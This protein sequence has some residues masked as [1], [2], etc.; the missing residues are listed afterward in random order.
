MIKHI[1]DMDEE[2]KALE[3]FN[4]EKLWTRFFKIYILWNSFQV[5]RFFLESFLKI[6][7]PWSLKNY[8]FS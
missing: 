7:S 6:T 5:I 1:Q 4:R 2:N 3:N 8:K